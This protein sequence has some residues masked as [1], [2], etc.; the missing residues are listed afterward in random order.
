M[1]IK[2]KHK[3]GQIREVEFFSV[4][5]DFCT[6]YQKALSAIDNATR[7]LQAFSDANN[8]KA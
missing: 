7:E 3:A 6:R 4:H 1:G 8:G 5:D 2:R